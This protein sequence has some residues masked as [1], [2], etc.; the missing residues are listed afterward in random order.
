[1]K[2]ANK[3]AS[4]AKNAANFAHRYVGGAP[5]GKTIGVGVTSP[6]ATVI[7]VTVALAVFDPSSFTDCGETVQ[8]G[9]TGATM[10]VH[11]TVWSNPCAGAAETVKLA[12][13]PALIV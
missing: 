9:P 10:Q 2:S 5:R 1:L 8:P 6:R 4:P 3:T 12:C 7:N 13:C 11:V